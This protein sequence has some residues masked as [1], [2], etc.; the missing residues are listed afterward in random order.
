MPILFW[1]DVAAL[2]VSTIILTSLA[3][4]VVGVRLRRELHQAF[5]L[6]S[7]AGGIWAGAALALRLALWLNSIVP[8][9]Q[10]Y[11][12]SLSLELTGLS[13][14]LM[15]NFSARFAV[16]YLARRSRWTDLFLNFGLLLALVLSI[17]LFNHQLVH[18]ASLTSTGMVSEIISPWGMAPAAL[19]V[20]YLA[21]ALFLFWQ[22][23]G[24]YPEPYLAYSIL[25]LLAG[26]L[27][28][29]IL[30]VPF[31]FLS[32]SNAA[33]AAL[34]AYVAVIRQLFNPLRE[35]TQ[36]LQNEIIERGQ[37]EARFRALSAA[38]FEGIGF[39]DHGVIVDANQQLADILG[40]PI[41]ELPGMRFSQLIAPED[42][43]MV[44]VRT[45]TGG[46]EPFEHRVV[47]KD[48]SLIHVE[49]RSRTTERGG[50]PLRVTAVRDIT[51]RVRAE[52]SLRH[53]TRRLQIL[54]EI[55]QGILASRSPEAIAGSAVTHIRQ[56][57]PCQR[58]SINL[59]DMRQRE[60][61]VLAVDLEEKSKIAV[62]TRFS[63][64]PF[65]D[66]IAQVS[67]SSVVLWTDL[68]SRGQVGQDL[69][70]EG[71]RAYL[72]APLIFEGELIGALNLAAVAAD[73]FAREHQ[74]LLRQVA[75][76]LAIAIRQAQLQDQIQRHA[77]ELEQRVANRTLELSALYEV[78]SLASQPLD[79][80]TMLSQSLQLILEVIEG[81]SGSIHLLDAGDVRAELANA[82]FRLV[83]HQGVR[84]DLLSML[85]TYPASEGL[86]EW[87]LSHNEPLIVPDVTTDPRMI[88]EL[89]MDPRTF[90]GIP[91]RSSGQTIGVLG[92]VRRP[93]QRQLS[94]EELSMLGSI[95]DQLGIVVE[96]ARLHALSEEAARL[97]ERERLARELHDSVTQSLYSLTLFAEW[98]RDL[99]RDGQMEAV[100]GRLVRIGETAQQAL[101]EMRLLIYELR[102]ALLEQEGLV[103]ALER[104]LDAVEK[105]AG[106]QV[107]LQAEQLGRLPPDVEVALYRIAQEALNNALKH[108]R[109]SQISASGKPRRRLCRAGDRG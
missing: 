43:E 53:F 1:V 2:C 95:A 15:A 12:T 78:A 69:Y 96:S 54:H 14:S 59:I 64:E 4:V 89:P 90:L 73:A 108:A 46:D 32:V 19:V 11:N 22:E 35:L 30:D 75:D 71:I 26:V 57:V 82:T 61:A 23:R 93:D 9:G 8:A 77:R 7:L 13:L 80:E 85:D 63:M 70:A 48:G 60:M 25:A 105:R 109:A 91:L 50:V 103:Q 41:E 66:L 39:H 86:G 62:G 17:P 51:E 21:Y 106:V 49:V 81:D 72:S 5:A 87:I 16:S 83:A 31:P 98:G 33:S 97:E 20:I 94:I 6:F 56:L 36:D 88:R 37:S 79:L 38:T 92:I 24:R 29:G 55:E 34:L 99:Y 40:Y 52:E 65:A 74:D 100:E 10:E 76:Q 18:S 42:R 44:A 3:L 102:P 45:R 27:V 101:K 107:S 104:R 67:D 58:V 28:G 84:A 68:L 47:R